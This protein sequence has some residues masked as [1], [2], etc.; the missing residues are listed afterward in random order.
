MRTRL[1]DVLRSRAPR[2]AGRDGRRLVPPPRRRRL[3]RPAASAASARRRWV[4]RRWS[5]R[6]R[7]IR[8]LTTKPF[9]VDLLTA[10]AGQMETQ[11]Q[12]SST[13]ALA[14]SSPASACPATSIDLCHANNVLVVSMCGKVRHAIAAVEAGCD[15]VVA[16]GTEAGGHTGK[17]A[18]MA[19]V[20]QV[21]D[22]VGER[23][24]GRRGRRHLRRPRAR[25]VARARRR[26]HLGRH[27]LHRH[28][29]GPQRAGY[30]DVLLGLPED[31]TVVSRAYTGKTCRV[32]RNDWTK[33]FEEHPGRAQAVPAADRSTRCQG[34]REPP[35]RRRAHDGRPRPRVLPVRP[36]RRRDQRAPSRRRARAASSSPRPRRSS[37]GYAVGPADSL[38]KVTR[39]E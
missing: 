11:V 30:K 16:Q 21:V 4:T 14:C 5:T 29:R 7:K 38:L 10:V 19:L 17:I 39:R 23:V 20:P 12:T 1:T 26:R 32:V 22:A 9:G 31:G 37:T 18:T 6:S 35:R 3:A 25:R 27:P 13:A 2:D 36:G 8:E 34:R 33:H 28:A 15:I 24:P